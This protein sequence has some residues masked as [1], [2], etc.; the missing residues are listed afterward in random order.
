MF[1]LADKLRRESTGLVIRRSGVRA[2][3]AETVSV[4]IDTRQRA[5]A[6]AVDRF[7]TVNHD[8]L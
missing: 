1:T 2:R 5:M 7:A 3:G 6:R 4:M 8:H